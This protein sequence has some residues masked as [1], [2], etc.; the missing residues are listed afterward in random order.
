[1]REH[2]VNKKDNFIGGWYMDNT[3]IC[4][5]II[6]HHELS[7]NKTPGII[8]S[9]G[10]PIV[11]P[12]VKQST[13]VIHWTDSLRRE[14]YDHLSKAVNAY[15]QKYPACAAICSWRIIE[16]INIQHYKPNEGYHA[17]HCERSSGNLPNVNRLLAFMTYLNEVAV[18]GG[19]EFIHQKIITKAE[20]GLTLI[21]PADWM[22]MHRGIPAPNQHK[23]VVTGWFSLI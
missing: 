16:D 20:K 9:N 8:G 3:S 10:K 22:F 1:M 17:V 23:Y 14:Y 2:K 18:E 21:W 5:K 15:K 13:D 11:D 12:K 4:D 6:R 7:P 19:T